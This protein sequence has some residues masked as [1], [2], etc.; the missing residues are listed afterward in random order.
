LE[1]PSLN[2]CSQLPRRFAGVTIGCIGSRLP[3]HPRIKACRLPEKL[4]EVVSSPKAPLAK[5]AGAV[6]VCVTKSNW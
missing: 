4:R 1:K 6:I 5:E 3:D 2:S